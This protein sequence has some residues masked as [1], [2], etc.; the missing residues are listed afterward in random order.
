M[1]DHKLSTVDFSYYGCSG[2]GSSGTLRN[3]SGCFSLGY[4]YYREEY[5]EQHALKTA[6]RPL[7]GTLRLIL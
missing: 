4:L 3:C 7:V 2:V 5:A 1:G 6:T